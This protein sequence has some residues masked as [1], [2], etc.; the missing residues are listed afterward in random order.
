MKKSIQ[1]ERVNLT[2]SKPLLEA[3]DRKADAMNICRNDLI[4]RALEQ[5]VKSR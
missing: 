5:A 4:R 2:L 1:T 3:V